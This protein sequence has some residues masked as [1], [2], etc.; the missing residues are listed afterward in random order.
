MYS[1]YPLLD[2]GGRTLA[3]MATP[4]APGTA[5]IA[6]PVPQAVVC[7]ALQADLTGIYHDST[8]YTSYVRP[9]PDLFGP[10]PAGPIVCVIPAATA[11][12]PGGFTTGPHATQPPNHIKLRV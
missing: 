12:T 6:S 2:P 9:V 3:S 10:C 4:A 8:L 5:A 1:F 7:G 11:T